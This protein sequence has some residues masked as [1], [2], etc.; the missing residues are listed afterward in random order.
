MA[1]RR[2][3]EQV[4]AAEAERERAEAEARRRDHI[5]ESVTK[6]A[7]QKP[8]ALAEVLANWLEQEKA[9]ASNRAATRAKA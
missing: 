7:L 4:A 6:M 1:Q 8:E 9:P 3:A 2:A 5:R